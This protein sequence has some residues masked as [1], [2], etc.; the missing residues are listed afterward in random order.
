MEIDDALKKISEIHGHLT[1]TELYRGF[2]AI[3]IALTGVTALV[4]AW[5]QPLVIGDASGR[6]FGRMFVLFWVVVAGLI[7]LFV[8]VGILRNYLSEKSQVA[9]RK[10]RAALGQLLPAVFAGAIV[11]V[12]IALSGGSVI[13]YLPGLWAIFISLGIFAS[14]LYLP[15]N[16]GWIAAFYIVAGALLLLIADQGASLSPWGMGLTFGIG[17]IATSAVFF[18]NLERNENG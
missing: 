12:P 4:A 11:T 1:K 5:L 9:R 15:R 13:A 3:P 7:A 6:M 2:R 18:W 17:Q 10:T 8:G 16:T 14:R